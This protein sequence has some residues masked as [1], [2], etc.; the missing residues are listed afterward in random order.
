MET[1]SAVS[2]DTTLSHDDRRDLRAASRRLQEQGYSLI[3]TARSLGRSAQ[4]TRDDDSSREYHAAFT[5]VTLDPYVQ[6]SVYVPMLSYYP[7][8]ILELASWF[9][10]KEDGEVVVIIW[11][12]GQ[13]RTISSLVAKSAASIMRETN[14]TSHDI[15]LLRTALDRLNAALLHR[16]TSFF[17]GAYDSAWHAVTY[18]DMMY[19]FDTVVRL[20]GSRNESLES[21]FAYIPPDEQQRVRRFAVAFALDTVGDVALVSLEDCRTKELHQRDVVS[22]LIALQ[23]W[24]QVASH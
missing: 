7:G 19:P 9:T 3:Q 18:G 6:L 23:A 22:M 11:G 10:H 12:S 8:S 1:M 17:V 14:L 16:A 24:A 20:S 2:D 15:A 4:R 5:A 13:F 21:I